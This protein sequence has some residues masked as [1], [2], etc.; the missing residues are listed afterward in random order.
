MKLLHGRAA[1]AEPPAR[2][3]PAEGCVPSGCSPIPQLRA[4]PPRRAAC[5]LT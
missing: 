1:A 5:P 4:S 3:G 2:R